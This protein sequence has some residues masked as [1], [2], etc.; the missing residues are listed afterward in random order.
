MYIYIYIC[1]YTHHMLALGSAT[2]SDRLAVSRHQTRR[3]RTLG[4]HIYI[5]IYA[6]R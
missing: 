6:Y 5:Y 2:S 4:I 1:M 3:V